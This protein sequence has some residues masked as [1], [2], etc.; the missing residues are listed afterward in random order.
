MAS[1]IPD[2]RNPS[3]PR[4]C[5]AAANEVCVEGWAGVPVAHQ[6]GAAVSQHCPTVACASEGQNWSAEDS[7]PPRREGR[8]QEHN[9]ALE[10]LLWSQRQLY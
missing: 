1:R 6:H 7:K 4:K 8:L 5:F 10:W 9:L 3:A 2:G